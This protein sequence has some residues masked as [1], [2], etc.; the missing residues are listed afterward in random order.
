MKKTTIRAVEMTRRIRDKQYEQLKDKPREQRLAFY[1]A[2]AQALHAKVR[3]LLQTHT[4]SE[5]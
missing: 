2:K 4:S 3:A 1:Q 5:R